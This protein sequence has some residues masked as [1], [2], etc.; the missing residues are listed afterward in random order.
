MTENTDLAAQVAAL[1]GVRVVVVGDVM[2]DRFLYGAVERISPEGPIPVLRVEREAAMLG[3]AGN[4][5]RN[6]AAL[7]AAVEFFAVAGDD[8][9]GREVQALAQ[10]AAGEGCHL[11]VEAGRPTTIKE[12]YIAAGQ[13]LLRADR[14][15]TGAIDADTAATLLAAATAALK[16]AGALV[17]SDYGKGVLEPET[18]RVLI[19]AA[20]AAGCPVVVDPKGRDYGIYRGAT[21]VTPNQR[22]LH[23]ASGRPTG[24]DDDVL[25]AAQAIIEICGIDGVLVTRGAKGMTVLRDGEGSHLHLPAEAR[26]VFDVS[27]AGDTVV[28]AVGAALAAGVDFLSAVRLA[29]VAA[30]IVVG[31][32]GTAV[33]SR[34][35]LLRA[36]HA[37]DLLAAETKIA[38]LEA[39]V[40]HA[41][42]WRQKGLTVGFTNGCFDLL[43]PGHVS[44]LAQARAA[45]DR[46]IVGLNSDASTRRLKGD[47]RPIQSEA[48]RAAVLASLADVDLVVIFGEDTPL[49]SIE[50]LKPDVLV[51][52]AD[53]ARNEVVG[54]DLVERNGGKLIL[55][56][57]SPGHS[58]SDTIGRMSG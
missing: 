39:S 11:L 31:K 38:D 28:A 13:Q 21:L 16:S 49:K 2:L 24:T 33:A 8:G 51:K 48:A 54:A 52:G 17:L 53:Y 25:L 55:V 32:L 29:N 3:G 44:L 18:L 14:D 35:E 37:S 27:G 5:L 4:V 34:G 43:H 50:A 30:S 47:G 10:E 45:C 58:T 7:G 1:A 22:E 15:P 9:A 42:R 20:R 19:A 56:E 41:A 46:L 26:E 40:E 57:L 6:L 36:L 23:E 12:R